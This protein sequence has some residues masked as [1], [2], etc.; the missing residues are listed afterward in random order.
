M[1]A[2]FMMILSEM[3]RKVDCPADL[4]RDGSFAVLEQCTRIRRPRL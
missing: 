4:L 1:E 2:D 3:L